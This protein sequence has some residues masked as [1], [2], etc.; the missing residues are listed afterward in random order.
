M[1]ACGMAE[2]GV[3]CMRRNGNEKLG[4]GEEDNEKRKK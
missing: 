3:R 1:S 2:M 4:T